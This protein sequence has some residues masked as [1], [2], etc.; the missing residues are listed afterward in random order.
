MN[1]WPVWRVEILVWEGDR[2][3]SN[4][5]DRDLIYLEVVKPFQVYML[6]AAR[7]R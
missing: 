5:M 6:R 4:L 1:Y 3:R 2:T 7:T